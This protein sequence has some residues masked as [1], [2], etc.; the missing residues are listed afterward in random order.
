MTYPP[1]PTLD[2][3]HHIK[4]KSHAIGDFLEWLSWEKQI[5]LGKWGEKEK[6]E[7]SF[8]PHVYSIEKLLA[9]YFDIDLNEAEKEK[10]AILEHLNK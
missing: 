3:M 4:E 7:E 6:G 10:R 2:K 8:Y 1:T 9:E 5:T